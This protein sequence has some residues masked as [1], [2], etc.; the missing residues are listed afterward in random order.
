MAN[1]KVLKFRQLRQWL[2]EEEIAAE[3]ERL[4]QRH[5]ELRV[6]D[7]GAAE[8]GDITVIDFDGYVD[9]VPFEG[10]KSER[11]SLELGSGSFIP[12]FEEQVV[13]LSTWRLQRY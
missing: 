3:L 6:I 13:G 1:T 5:A 4:Q 7:E 10:G 9:G 8:N 2:A 12:G 11:H